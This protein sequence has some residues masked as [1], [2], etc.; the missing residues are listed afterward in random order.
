MIHRGDTE[1][2]ERDRDIRMNQA[3]RD[4]R[5]VGAQR[6]AP[7]LSPHHSLLITHH[8]LLITHHSLLVTHYSSLITHY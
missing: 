4:K 5:L 7:L 3:Q 6:A 2:T 1:D 8:S